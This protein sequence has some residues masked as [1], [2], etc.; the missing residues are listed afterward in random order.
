MT[1]GVVHYYTWRGRSIL[2]SPLIPFYSKR[3]YYKQIIRSN[4]TKYADALCGTST[5]LPSTK[6]SSPY[7]VVLSITTEW[8]VGQNRSLTRRGVLRIWGGVCKS[9]QLFEDDHW[10][11]IT[12]YNMLTMNM[13]WKWPYARQ[14]VM[15]WQLAVG[16]GRHHRRRSGTAFNF[17]LVSKSGQVKIY[18]TDG[19]NFSHTF[20]DILKWC[21]VS[22]SCTSG[23]EAKKHVVWKTTVCV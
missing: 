21:Y 14:V 7:T 13:E 5:E 1:A 8:G 17:F 19:L 16:V 2:N 12:C 6:V 18:S 23:Y 11:T 20:W 22:S 3:M 9:Q 4:Q 15:K 10:I